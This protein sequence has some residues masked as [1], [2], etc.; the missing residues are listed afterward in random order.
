MKRGDVQQAIREMWENQNA[1]PD[2]KSG[3]QNRG[4]ILSPEGS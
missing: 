3:S 2:D 1:Q 4:P